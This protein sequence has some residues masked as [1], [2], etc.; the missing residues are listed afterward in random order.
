MDP[1]ARRQ[2]WDILQKFK[3]G[4]TVVL[5]THFMDEADVLGDR[6]AIM[7]IGSVQFICSQ[8][9]LFLFGFPVFDYERI[10]ET[11]LLTKLDVRFHYKYISFIFNTSKSFLIKIQIVILDEPTS[12]MDP[13]ARRQIWDIL[14]KFKE[15]RT[16]VLST[17]FMDEADLLGENH[18]LLDL[19]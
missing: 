14:Q 2:I 3:E 18:F 13:G 4:R 6:I 16:V 7:L 15:G 5:S 10:P 11:P 17:H 12:G 8:R 19:H 1:D 9:L